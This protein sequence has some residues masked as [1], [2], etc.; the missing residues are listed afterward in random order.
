MENLWSHP[1]LDG[2]G[3]VVAGSFD[4]ESDTDA[5]SDKNYC[6]NTVE[7]LSYLHIS[8]GTPAI[9]AGSGG[10]EA[11]DLS[12]SVSDPQF[13]P[14]LHTPT[15]TST[16]STSSAFTAAV[17]QI[18]RLSK[19]TLAGPLAGLRRSPATAKS[20]WAADFRVLAVS[21]NIVLGSC[22]PHASFSGAHLED[23][24]GYLGA[25]PSARS[26]GWEFHVSMF[27]SDME[28]S[29][30]LLVDRAAASVPLQFSDCTHGAPWRASKRTRESYLAELR[31]AWRPVPVRAQRTWASPVTPLA[32]R[33]Q[34]GR[35]AR[36]VGSHRVQSKDTI[37]AR[38][39][40]AGSQGSSGRAVVQVFALV[41]ARPDGTQAECP[42]SSCASACS[43]HTEPP[44]C[45][46]TGSRAGD[47]VKAALVSTS[48][49]RAGGQVGEPTFLHC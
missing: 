8:F 15:H 11:W 23:E 9:R 5:L 27:R 35:V 49:R 28:P 17:K 45:C 33:E 20:Q 32:E 48:L 24:R 42:M 37:H 40:T 44:R 29:G 26:S 7:G 6:R 4:T 21:F 43:V 10:A 13:G 14:H 3:S 16:S 36:G 47:E 22:S 30:K 34:A 38:G 1:G 2:A 46:R 25:V 41:L 39:V 19:L 12:Q 18:C 31:A